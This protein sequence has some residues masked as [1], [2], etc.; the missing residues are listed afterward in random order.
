MSSK[1]SAGVATQVGTTVHGMQQPGMSA[2]G[3]G[4]KGGKWGRDVTYA[5]AA[6]LVFQHQGGGCSQGACAK[7]LP[8][9]AAVAVEPLW[10]TGFSQAV[11][12][13]TRALG[14]GADWDGAD[15]SGD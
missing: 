14:D 2:S 8:A 1:T 3:G 15:L 13:M 4:A 5:N 7:L 12:C 9:L 6:H 11:P 10:L